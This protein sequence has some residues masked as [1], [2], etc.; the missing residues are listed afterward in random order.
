M[1]SLFYVNEAML[2]G[3]IDVQSGTL[4]DPGALPAQIHIQTADRIGWM[5]TEHELPVFEHYPG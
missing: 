3:M 4:D 5:E 1:S 2:P